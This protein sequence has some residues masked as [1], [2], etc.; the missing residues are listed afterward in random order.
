MT[1]TFI[2]GM[3]NMSIDAISKSKNKV[4]GVKQVLKALE[5][6]QVECVF[7]ATDVDERIVEPILF[8]CKERNISV[9]REITKQELGKA[10]GIQ[11]GATA[12][13]LLK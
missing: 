2:E 12:V 6:D 8:L 4:V 7:I 10:C 3:F 5:R 11:V 9:T 13:G 1:G